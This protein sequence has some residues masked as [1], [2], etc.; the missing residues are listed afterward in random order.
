MAL[1]D[2]MK[3]GDEN[4]TESDAHGMASSETPGKHTLMI[5]NLP[6]KVTP[7]CFKAVLAE[8]GYD[9][10]YNYL[11]VPMRKKG[12]LGFGFVNFP[13]TKDAAYFAEDIEGY[14]FAGTFS[15]KTCHA[16]FADLQGPQAHAGGMRMD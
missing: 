9:G 7:E 2:A 5:R 11:Y 6:C 12:C 4:A 8:L 16:V 10:K 15:N 1:P 13:S 14:R 3:C